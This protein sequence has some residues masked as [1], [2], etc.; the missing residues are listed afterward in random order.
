MHYA[1]W[2]L[3]TLNFPETAREINHR[4]VSCKTMSGSQYALALAMNYVPKLSPLQPYFP[5]STRSG[6]STYGVAVVRDY[7]ALEQ[8]R[9]LGSI[10]RPT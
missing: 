6:V 2:A 7:V 5:L 3:S 1:L 10:N 4:H 9:K 8:A